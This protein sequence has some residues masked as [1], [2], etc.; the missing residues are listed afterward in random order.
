MGMFDS[1]WFKCP[2]CGNQ[3]E[4]QSKAGECVLKNISPDDVPVDIAVDINGDILCCEECDKTFTI[5]VWPERVPQTV[6]MRTA[7]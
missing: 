4:K 6:K 5:F 2:K 1:V 3:V 7:G